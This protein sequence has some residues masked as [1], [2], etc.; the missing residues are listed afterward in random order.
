MLV[1]FLS[2]VFLVPYLLFLL[3]WRLSVLL[4]LIESAA[5]LFLLLVEATKYPIEAYRGSCYVSLF[6]EYNHRI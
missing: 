1:G 3:W 2:A 4:R 6:T 5:S